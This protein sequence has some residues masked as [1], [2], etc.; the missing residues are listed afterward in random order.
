MYNLYKIS[1]NLYQ[2]HSS[3]HNQKAMEGTMIAIV[4]YCVT[5][6]RFNVTEIEDA[7]VDMIHKET[8]AAHFGIHRKFLY[9]FNRSQK[10]AG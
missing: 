8:D 5:R 1:D 2:I 4:T 7:M 6:L 9:S 3:Y 10:K